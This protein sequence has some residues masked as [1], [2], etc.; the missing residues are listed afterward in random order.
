MA[1]AIPSD[2]PTIEP[3][4]LV[5][6]DPLN[7]EKIVKSTE[8]YQETLIGAISTQPGVVLGK[9]DQVGPKVGL[10]GRIPVKVSTINGPIYKGDPITSS[11]I[12][13]VGMKA[14]QTGMIIGR[15][16]EDWTDPDPNKIGKIIV[17]L[18]NTQY[19]PY[20]MIEKEEGLVYAFDPKTGEPTLK[21]DR[22]GE[23]EATK[24]VSSP[25]LITDTISSRSDQGITFDLD[26]LSL[27]H[28]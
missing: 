25:N 12:P 11:S 23:I 21:L 7:P 28:I 13:G 24:S 6:L 4:D 17:F 18:Q 16:M 22:T 20:V 15:A 19:R 3:G 26:N 9:D 5:A 2:D 27:I 14:T 8:P 1:E 10:A